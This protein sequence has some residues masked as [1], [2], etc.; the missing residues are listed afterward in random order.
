M[1]SGKLSVISL[2]ENPCEVD[3]LANAHPD[4]ILE[5]SRELLEWHR[6]LPGAATMPKGAGSF[7]Y[8]WP[9]RK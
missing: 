8:P 2:K 4:R 6:G 3:N 7:D 5:M 1:K 9:G